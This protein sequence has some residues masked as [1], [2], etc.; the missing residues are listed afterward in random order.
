MGPPEQAKPV[1]I[2]VGVV[3]QLHQSDLDFGHVALERLGNEP[4]GAGVVVEDLSPDVAEVARRLEDLRPQTLVL[5]SATARG[6][7]PGKVQRRLAR[8]A[9]LPTGAVRSELGPDADVAPRGLAAVDHVLEVASAGDTPTRIVVVEVEV[10]NLEPSEQLSPP[11][12]EAVEAALDR[13]RAE[14]RRVPLLDLAGQVRDFMTSEPLDPTPVVEAVEALLAELAVLEREGR[15]GR[16]F[17]ERD[18]L[19][20]RISSGE[21]AGDGVGGLHWAMWW[22]LIEELD[23]LQAL[24]AVSH[25]S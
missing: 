14:V 2:L 23:R 7:P 25:R 17:A 21:H 22:A 8:S 16:T 12:E 1:T 13:V 4:L 6:R 24:E 20:L 11:V 3:R 10:A 9:A 18:R 5:V 19:K 15:W